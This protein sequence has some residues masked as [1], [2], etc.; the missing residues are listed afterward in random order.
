M[1]FHPMHRET[2]IALNRYAVE[3]FG[4]GDGSGSHVTWLLLQFLHPMFL[5]IDND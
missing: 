5:V 1:L 4:N 2:Y 3:N